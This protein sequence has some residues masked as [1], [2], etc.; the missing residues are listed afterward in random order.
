MLA[1]YISATQVRLARVVTRAGE[2]QLAD[3]AIYR[4]DEFPDFTSILRTYFSKTD[5]KARIACFG[6]AGTVIDNEVIQARFPWAIDL[7]ILKREFSLAGVRLVNDLVATAKGIFELP[8]EKFY[9]IKEGNSVLTGNIALLAAGPGLGEALIY[10]DDEKYVNV[11]SEGG[12]AAFAPTS[13]LEI[14]LWEHLYGLQPHV[15]VE[16]V[17]SLRGIDNIYRFMVKRSGS[18]AGEWYRKAVDKP[19]AIIETALAGR[20][21]MAVSALELFVECLASEA[22]NLALKGI[23]VG[24]VYLG[25]VIAPQI[26]TSLDKGSFADRFVRRGTMERLLKEMPVTVIMD[27]A[28]AL[29]GAGCLALGL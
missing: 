29:L 15:E 2:V 25:G 5:A 14:E 9:T 8:S 3:I 1:G 22:A 16:D 23:T 26:V 21:E 19:D 24:G 17:V 12:H 7:P 10:Y 28:A 13:Q 6:V 18:P 20:D 11:A 27:D 4:N